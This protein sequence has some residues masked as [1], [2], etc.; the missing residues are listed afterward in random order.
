[1]RQG[2]YSPNNPTR[3]RGSDEGEEKPKNR[4]GG[5]LGMEFFFMEPETHRG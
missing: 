2:S 4:A 1:V 5:L 3:K